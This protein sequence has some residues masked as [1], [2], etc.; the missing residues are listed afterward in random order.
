MVWVQPWAGRPAALQAVS[1]PLLCTS[2][3]L[4]TRCSPPQ[5]QQQQPWGASWGPAGSLWP[6][7]V[8]GA[9][10]Q[11]TVPGDGFVVTLG[12][13][14]SSCRPNKIPQAWCLHANSWTL[15]S[16]ESRNG[17]HSAKSGVWAGLPSSWRLQPF[18]LLRSCPLPL[19]L[20]PFLRLQSRRGAPFFRLFLHLQGPVKMSGHLNDPGYHF[21]V[22]WLATVTPPLPCS[23]VW[24]QVWGKML[25]SLREGHSAFH[26]G[27][28]H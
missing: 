16:I 19:A 12:V 6:S 11:L 27:P 22:T 4:T 28:W 1:G 15:D 21:K 17:P 2:L 25:T 13:W 26:R 5:Q 10:G 18:Q 14:V 9:W 7:V 3:P 20:G 23:P 24:S 8:P